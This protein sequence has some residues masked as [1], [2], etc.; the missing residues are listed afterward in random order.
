MNFNQ[1]WDKEIGDGD[2]YYPKDS[3]RLGW[4]AA[5]QEIIKLIEQKAN[6]GEDG[7]ICIDNYVLDK[8]KE[9]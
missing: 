8:I 1:W 7:I 2:G 4:D 9:L 6:G 3:A 5:K